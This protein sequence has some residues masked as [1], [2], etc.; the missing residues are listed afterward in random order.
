MI[1]IKIYP[2]STQKDLINNTLGCCNWIKNKYFASS[3]TCCKCGNKKKHLTLNDRVYHCKSCGNTIDRD[4]NAAINL[5]NLKN[6][7]CLIYDFA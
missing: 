4:L 7:K 6:S 3:K 2:N 5:L 1:K